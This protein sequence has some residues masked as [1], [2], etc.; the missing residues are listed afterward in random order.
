MAVKKNDSGTG[1][2]ADSAGIPNTRKHMP[3]KNIRP[4]P[5]PA[6]LEETGNGNNQRSR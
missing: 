4:K 5:S 1:K 6:P 3:E 2:P